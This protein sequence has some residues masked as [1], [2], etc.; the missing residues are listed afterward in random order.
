MFRPHWSDPLKR[1]VPNPRVLDV[2]GYFQG[3]SHFDGMAAPIKLS[4]NENAHGPSPA[5]I[6]AVREAAASAHIYPEGQAT[7]LNEALSERFRIPADRVGRSNPSFDSRIR[8]IR[9]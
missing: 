1:P 5:A 3:A 8:A 9:Q 7:V 4:S 2:P 6:D